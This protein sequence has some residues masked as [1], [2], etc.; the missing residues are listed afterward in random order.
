MSELKQ[1]RLPD[2]GEGLTEADIIKWHV[3]PGDKVTINQ[4]IVE[5]ETAKAVVELPSPYEGVVAGLLVPEGTTADVGTPIISVEVG[6]DAGSGASADGAEP[7]GVSGDELADVSSGQ[8]R[9][10]V[11]VTSG[12]GGEQPLAPR[13]GTSADLVPPPPDGSGTAGPDGG[14]GGHD[15]GVEPGI[16]GTLAPKEEK[17]ERH[18]VLVGYGVKPGSTTRRPRRTAAASAPAAAASA[19]AAAAP[20]PAAAGSALAATAS[21]P[22][23]SAAAPAPAVSAAFTGAQAGPGT[24]VLAKPPV[25]KLAKDLGV[26]LAQLTGTGPGGSITRDDVQGAARDQEAADLAPAGAPASPAQFA[27]VT[28]VAREE[29]IAIRGVRKHTAAA[30]TGSAFSAPHVTEF[31]QIDI[32]ETMNATARLRTLPEFSEVRVSPLL[33]VARA[34]MVA[35]ARHPMINSTWDEDAQEIVVRHYVNL[36]IAA[37]TDRGLVVPN[38]KDAHA[39]SLPGLA[40]ALA[41]LAETA[42][43]G[44]TTP[45]GLRGGTITITNVGVFGVDTGTPILTPGEAAILAFGQ[46]KDAPWVHEGQLAVRKVTTLALSFDHRIVDGDLG[47]AVLRDIGAMLEDPLRMLAWS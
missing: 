19:P 17:E 7:A 8:P 6:P 26:D 27:P 36:G 15:L 43:A 25:R 34:L 31:L 22:A 11:G 13:G 39:L 10:T 38:I 30:V 47:S 33:L 24:P 23:D 45:A 21:A 16:H 41:D 44:K 5:I 42:R 37:A 4:I 9:V 12:P 20:A 3:Q 40:R 1:F 18:S 28:A 2:V 32:T 29:R 14:L 35:V 46:V